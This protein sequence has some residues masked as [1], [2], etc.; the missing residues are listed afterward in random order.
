[1]V[2]M[3]RKGNASRVLAGKSEGKGPSGRSRSYGRII[4]KW[5]LRM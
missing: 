3:E 2:R 1:M 5:L 4:L